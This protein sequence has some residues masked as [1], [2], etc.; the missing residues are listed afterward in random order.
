MDDD[1]DAIR[2]ASATHAL[3]IRAEQQLPQSLAMEIWQHR[4][5]VYTQ[6]ASILPV[7]LGHIIA[8]GGDLHVLVSHHR[9]GGLGGDNL[10]QKYGLAFRR[11]RVD[12]YGGGGGRCVPG[13]VT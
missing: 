5:T 3:N 10:A 6:R 9:I 1:R 11:A 12:G 13:R 2:N 7:T 8:T 4:E